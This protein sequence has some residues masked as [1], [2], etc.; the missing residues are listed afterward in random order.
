MKKSR[1]NLVVSII[2]IVVLSILIVSATSGTCVR[3]G[4]VT[5]EW[6]EIEFHSCGCKKGI[7][8]HV[9]CT[10]RLPGSSP[11]EEGPPTH[12]NWS[13]SYLVEDNEH[14]PSTVG[15]TACPL[16]GYSKGIK[17]LHYPCGLVTESP[18]SHDCNARS[19]KPSK[20]EK[21]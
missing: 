1:I 14:V 19:T 17:V 12:C 3:C 9:K 16:C 5:K 13:T 10:G 18:V 15:Y 11:G 6:S 21:K 8:V 20:L 7:R 2:T 4:G